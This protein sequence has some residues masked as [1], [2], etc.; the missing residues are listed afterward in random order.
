MTISR[1]LKTKIDTFATDAAA[2]GDNLAC[3]IC[4]KALGFDYSDVELDTD[5]RAELAKMSK[6]ACLEQATEWV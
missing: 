4:L 5:E 1:S 3:A 2:H 6:S